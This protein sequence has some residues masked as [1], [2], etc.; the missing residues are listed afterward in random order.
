MDIL[1]T[2]VCVNTGLLLPNASVIAVHKGGNSAFQQTLPE[3]IVG[4]LCTHGASMHTCSIF[5][6]CLHIHI[7]LP[8]THGASR[9]TLF[10]ATGLHRHCHRRHQDMC[11]VLTAICALDWGLHNQG[12][13]TPNPSTLSTF[14]QYDVATQ[15]HLTPKHMV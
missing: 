14:F 3:Y 9:H 6:C 10:T 4:H 8:D 7:V 11:I 15:R 2:H 1:S 5:T 12:R 13:T